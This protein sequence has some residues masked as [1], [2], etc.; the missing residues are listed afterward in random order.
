MGDPGTAAEGSAAHPG[1]RSL[2]VPLLHPGAASSILETGPG[3]GGGEGSGEH[4]REEPSRRRRRRRPQRAECL[5]EIIRST[6]PSSTPYSPP[7]SSSS[8]DPPLQV[9]A[10]PDPG[11]EGVGAP[12]R[13]TVGRV[14]ALAPGSGGGG[15]GR[16]RLIVLEVYV[17][18]DAR[19][20]ARVTGEFAESL[21]RR[22][23][24]SA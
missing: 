10:V 23:L 3:W 13:V 5:V 24:V 15:G 7:P 9:A 21:R 16:D 12:L 18:G 2:S 19:A 8:S 6:P 17:V 22:L 1:D 14:R 11:G 4:R 20:G